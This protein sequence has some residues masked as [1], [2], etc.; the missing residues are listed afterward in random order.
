VS[1]DEDD[2]EDELGSLQD[3][4]DDDVE[5][6]VSTSGGYEPIDMMAVYRSHM[7]LHVKSCL[8]KLKNSDRLTTRHCEI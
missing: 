4:I 8:I 5:T 7:N 2:E 6:T 1:A 3:F